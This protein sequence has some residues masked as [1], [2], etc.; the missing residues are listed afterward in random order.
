MAEFMRINGY[1]G[2]FT[3]DG[4]LKSTSDLKMFRLT[5]RSTSN[6]S[7]TAID[8]QD[9]DGDNAATASTTEADQLVELVIKELNPLMYQTNAAATGVM[10]ALVHGHNVDAAQIKARI[11][12]MSRG[13]TIGSDTAV[14]QVTGLT[15]V[16]V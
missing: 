12:G 8:L 7:N 3:A 4:L 2:N 14:E 9:K 15:T 10:F 5:L 16:T 1:F 11:V 6:G 13:A